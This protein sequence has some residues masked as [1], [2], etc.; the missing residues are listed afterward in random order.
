[1]TENHVI[2]RNNEYAYIYTLD[3]ED[4]GI[5]LLTKL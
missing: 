3:I 2:V 5:S 1:M 4:K